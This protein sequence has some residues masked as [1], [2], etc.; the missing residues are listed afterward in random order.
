[1]TMLLCISWKKNESK[2]GSGLKAFRGNNVCRECYKIVLFMLYWFL[3]LFYI[4]G[5]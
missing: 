1:M 4:Y 5:K 3:E 2:K